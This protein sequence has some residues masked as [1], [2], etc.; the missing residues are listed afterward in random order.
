MSMKN[1]RSVWFCLSVVSKTAITLH[2]KLSDGRGYTVVDA[3]LF[4]WRESAHQDER[5]E[6]LGARES[7]TAE[8]VVDVSQN[9]Q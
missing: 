7:V 4:V 1:K 5:I 6:S 3:L 9:I 8:A 2:I